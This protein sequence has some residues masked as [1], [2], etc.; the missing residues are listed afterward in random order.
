MS[1]PII[2]AS[3]VDPMG[4]KNS[5]GGS[6]VTNYVDYTT[7]K[8]TIFIPYYK[9]GTA[10]KTP[11]YQA[12]Q[13]GLSYSVPNNFRAYM[14]VINYTVSGD[15]LIQYVLLN[16][17]DQ[18]SVTDVQRS[19]GYTDDDRLVTLVFS[20]FN[21]FNKDSAGLHTISDVNFVNNYTTSAQTEAMHLACS[22]SQLKVGTGTEDYYGLTETSAGWMP[23]SLAGAMIEVENQ[24][25]S[26]NTRVDTVEAEV[27]AISTVTTGAIA[28]FPMR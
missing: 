28:R 7:D 26:L 22:P 4:N 25:T 11:L 19:D 1:L 6:R 2:K 27:G 5:V 20:S 16:T 3:I 9:N 14:W 24:I 12:L 13:T 10:T 23:K 8:P 17:N 21:R 18:V 15:F